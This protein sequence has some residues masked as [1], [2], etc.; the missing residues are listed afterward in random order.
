MV[1]QLEALIG[2]HPY[3]ERL[4]TQLTPALYRCDRFICM[5]GA[6]VEPDTALS[7]AYEFLHTYRNLFRILSQRQSPA[8]GNAGCSLRE[9]GLGYDVDAPEGG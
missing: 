9:L 8:R 5:R 2:E 6:W 4:R 3:R 1:G 7:E